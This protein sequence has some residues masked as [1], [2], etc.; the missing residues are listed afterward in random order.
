MKKQDSNGKNRK[1]YGVWLYG[2]SFAILAIG[3]LC[4]IVGIGKQQNSSSTIGAAFICIFGGLV[5][6]GFGQM[7]ILLSNIRNEL[8]DINEKLNGYAKENVQKELEYEKEN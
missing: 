7:Q 2:L 1:V 3:V 5:Y 6:M 4:L 8:Y